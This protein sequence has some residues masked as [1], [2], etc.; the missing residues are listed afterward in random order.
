MFE[1]KQ[2]QAS[3]PLFKFLDELNPVFRHQRINNSHTIWEL[4]DHIRI[5][6]EDIYQFMSNPQWKSP[7]W[8]QEYWP[9]KIDG[10]KDEKWEKTIFDFKEDFNKIIQFIQSINVNITPEIPHAKGYTFLREILLIGEHN[11]HHTGQML[12]LS[13]QLS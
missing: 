9:I 11:A 10:I 5:A 2:D 4:M 8:P 6:Q 12:Q 7:V 3:Y 13:K 1:V